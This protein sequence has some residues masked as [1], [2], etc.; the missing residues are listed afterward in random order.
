M[1]EEEFRQSLWAYDHTS[2]VIQQRRERARVIAVA[3]Q[4]AVEAAE[5]AAARYRVRYAR[6]ELTPVHSN[7]DEQL[8]QVQP[9]APSKR[10]SQHHNDRRLPVRR[11]SL[12]NIHGISAAPRNFYFLG[13]APSCLTL[14]QLKKHILCNPQTLWCHSCKLSYSFRC[15]EDFQEHIL[16]VHNIILA[17]PSNLPR[18]FANSIT[19]S[20]LSGS[21]WNSLCY[22][23]ESSLTSD[24]TTEF[25]TPPQDRSSSVPPTPTY[26][27]K[28]FADRLHS[29]VTTGFTKVSL[30]FVRPQAAAKLAAQAAT[31]AADT[32]VQSPSATNTVV[33]RQAA[34]AATT[35][36]VE[37]QVLTVQ[38]TPVLPPCPIHEAKSTDL[39]ALLEAPGTLCTCPIPPP[40]PDCPV[41]SHPSDWLTLQTVSIG[42]TCRDQ[43]RPQLP[44]TTP[45]NVSKEDTERPRTRFQGVPQGHFRPYSQEFVPK[46]KKD[47]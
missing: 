4:L 24:S 17:L 44:L 25:L 11:L 30:D 1:R 15:L 32:K 16:R 26:Q 42:C 28:S 8:H 22:K 14:T 10:D 38:E 46:K 23:S 45:I 20:D 7:D 41:H 6:G 34:A 35:S 5:A 47:E 40:S 37:P 2:E 18:K 13:H 31:A 29:A 9:P 33:Q 3:A 19:L 27:S 36:N 12:P 39:T 43:V 21:T